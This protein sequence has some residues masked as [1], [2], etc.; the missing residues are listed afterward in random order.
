M[1]LVHVDS[2][3]LSGQA[4]GFARTLGH[5]RAVTFAG[6][7]QPAAWAK[8]LAAQEAELLGQGADA[9][10]RVVEVLRELGVA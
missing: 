3:E 6:A 7:Y 4:V 1:I 10:P 2:D 5:V 9:A 8:A